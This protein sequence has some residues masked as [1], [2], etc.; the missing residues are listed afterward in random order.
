MLERAGAATV[1]AAR[2]AASSLPAAAASAVSPALSPAAIARAKKLASGGMAFL[3]A[4][5]RSFMAQRNQPLPAPSPSASA[6][7]AAADGSATALVPSSAVTD[8]SS[9]GAAVSDVS[10]T[11]TTA[12]ATSPSNSFSLLR[13][14]CT[15]RSGWSWF[16][17]ALL[18]AGAGGLAFGAYKVYL[19]WL[20]DMQRRHTLRLARA[21]AAAEAMAARNNAEKTTVTASSTEESKED[22]SS[23]D[24]TASSRP[25]ASMP[26]GGLSAFVALTSLISRRYQL[27]QRYSAILKHVRFEASPSTSSPSSLTLAGASTAPATATASASSSATA[28]GVS[29]SL[30]TIPPAPALSDVAKVSAVFDELDAALSENVYLKDLLRRLHAQIEWSSAQSGENEERRE[31]APKQQTSVQQQPPL[32]QSPSEP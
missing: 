20:M 29:S 3:E 12:A 13:W 11:A 14:L 8:P 7:A 24:G 25:V 1:D 4:P 28:A 32:Q 21:A 31:R 27:L 9:L 23:S 6:L 22:G 15:S 5:G 10:S 16:V 2:A 26:I 18:V 19:A 30:P 17:R